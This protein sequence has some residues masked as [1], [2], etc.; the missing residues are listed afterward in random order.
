MYAFCLCKQYILNKNGVFIRGKDKTINFSL[1][2]IVLLNSLCF[3]SLNK[4]RE[5]NE[6]NNII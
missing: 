1:Y 4:K 2:A 6:L 5:K 3:I